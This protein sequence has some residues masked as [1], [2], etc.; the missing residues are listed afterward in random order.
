ML[1]VIGWALDNLE[2]RLS[3]KAVFFDVDGTL[4][5]T[6]RD[7]HRVAFNQAFAALGVPIEWSVEEYGAWL[8]VTGGKERI[9][10]YCDRHPEVGEIDDALIERIHLEKVA[11]YRR[12]VESG[13]IVLRPGVARL[14]EELRSCGVV[15]G[16]TT[17]TML[18]SLDVLLSVEIGPHWEE[19]FAVVGAGDVVP[20]KK[21][22]PA[23]YSWALGALGAAS[24]EVVAVEDSRNGL[25]AATGA[26]IAT[27]VTPSY[28]TAGEDFSE[29]SLVA[30]GLG[31]PGKESRWR[32]RDNASGEGLVTQGVLASILS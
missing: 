8:A 15:M 23:I 20:K 3:L 25:L 1:V 18:D 17:T 12:I 4:A 29:A 10:A 27:L 21:P 26:G 14:I 11:A 19:I 31:D 16:I 7:G 24:S 6:E 5:E 13:G 32:G 28:Y 30:D 22:D 2:G 9:R